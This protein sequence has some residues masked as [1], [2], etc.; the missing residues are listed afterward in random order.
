VGEVVVNKLRSNINL[1]GTVVLEQGKV[2]NLGVRGIFIVIVGH[3]GYGFGIKRIGVRTLRAAGM[4]D[5]TI[6][7][8]IFIKR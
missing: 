8:Q 3:V 2:Y 6:S 5:L 1:K 7:T 4:N